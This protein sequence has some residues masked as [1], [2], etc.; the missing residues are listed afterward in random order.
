MLM[1][2]SILFLAMSSALLPAILAGC[3]QNDIMYDVDYNVT[4]AP[5]NTYYAG[6]P[7]TFNFSGEVDNLL[8]YSGERGHEYQYRDR[9]S[10]PLEEMSTVMLNFSVTCQY[11]NVPG[12]LDIYYSTTFP[13]LDGEDA[14]ADRATISAMASDMEAAGWTKLAVW[15][16]DNPE[17]PANSTLTTAN[18]SCD[19]SHAMDNFCLA[20]HWHPSEG[21][22]QNQA[23][24]T[25]RISGALDVET[26][27][28]MSLSSDLSSLVYRTFMTNDAF[29][30]NPYF[31][32][33]N[34]IPNNNNGAIRFNDS[35]YDIVFQGASAS[36][37]DFDLDGWCISVP[38]TLNAVANDT[39]TV[40]KNMQNYLDSYTYT[41]DEPGT[42]IVTFVGRNMNYVGTSELVREMTVTI[43]PQ[44]VSSGDG[45]A[46]GE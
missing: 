41:F 4:L 34:P 5:E 16:G 20:F 1:K 14:E 13:G 38:Q 18:V 19:L 24:R 33:T 22:N 32:N 11:G 3:Q 36:V 40:I 31:I 44:P 25:Y 9:Y 46:S 35:V 43:L 26:K 2:K 27:D 39:A 42:Y 15:G 30:E 8:F 21:P 6:E 10:I 45:G 17:E 12:G 23:Q 37:F 7:V 28:G 29:A